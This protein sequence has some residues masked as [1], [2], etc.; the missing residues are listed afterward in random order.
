[1]VKGGFTDSFAKLGNSVE[2]VERMPSP[3][4]VKSHLPWDLLPLQLKSKKPKVKGSF[5]YFSFIDRYH[6]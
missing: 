2:I 6:V 5:C 3:R 1:M 4:Y